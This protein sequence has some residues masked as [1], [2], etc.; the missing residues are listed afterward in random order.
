MPG[1]VTQED[2]EL[3]A[4]WIREMGRMEELGEEAEGE[5][6]EREEA[7]AEPARGGHAPPAPEP[8]A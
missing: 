8:W 3:A 5:G 4:E 7:A 1:G 2:A 6:R